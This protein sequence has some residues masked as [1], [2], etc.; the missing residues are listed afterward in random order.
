MCVFVLCTFIMYIHIYIYILMY[1]YIHISTIILYCKW[2][3]NSFG[4]I[5][6][7]SEACWCTRAKKR[8]I[9]HRTRHLAGES[10]VGEQDCFQFFSFKTQVCMLSP[11]AGSGHRNWPSQGSAETP[12][13]WWRKNL[14][15]TV[16]TG[17]HMETPCFPLRCPSNRP[18]WSF[19]WGW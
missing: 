10:L 6:E 8:E 1:I 14:H 19:F 11:S 15:Q 5:T 12:R 16:M 13:I 3:W 4:L 9:Y 2:I 18:F 7:S 17:K